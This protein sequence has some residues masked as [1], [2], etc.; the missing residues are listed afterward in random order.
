M[1]GLSLH[2]D[3]K[4]PMS[5][6]DYKIIKFHLAKARHVAKVSL[7]TGPEKPLGKVLEI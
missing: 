3:S 5:E 4:K 2:E 6:C 1:S 7:H